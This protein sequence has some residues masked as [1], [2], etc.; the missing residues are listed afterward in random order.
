MAVKVLVV[1]DSG[2]FRRR[3]TEMLQAD[4][5][6]EVVGAA[7]DGRDA[8]DKTRALN[9]DVITMDIEMPVMDGITAVRRIMATSPRPILMFSSL[10][11]EGA[12]AT[13]DALDA[14]AVDFLPKN[15]DDIS[16]NRDEVA[17][18]LRSRVWSVGVRGLRPPTP[19]PTARTNSHSSPGGPAPATAARVPRPRVHRGETRIVAIGTSTGGP[20]ALQQ[21]LTR[22]PANFSVPLVLIQHMP[23]SFT[24][25]FARRLDQL[26][27]ITVAEAVDGDF[28]EPGKALLAPG[29]KQML[30]EARGERL[31][32]SVTDSAPEQNYRPSVDLTFASI[33]KA[34]P[35][36][37][38]GIVLTGMGADGREGA[39]A[40][41]QTGATIWAQDEHT[42]VIYGMPMAIAQAGLAD[43]VLALDDIATRLVEFV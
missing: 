40:M 23:G 1:D 41:K 2:F 30:I 29:G 24:T 33:A 15:F 43:Q 4:P 11:H 42:S 34:V 19:A 22:L 8:I 6:L 20:V 26:C 10:T 21:V 35:S 31:R 28:L 32:V 12:Q 27:K 17:R 38:L 3:V 39:R 37:A 18:V 36:K 9:P 13:L 25:A 7:V 14:G 16:R 5:R